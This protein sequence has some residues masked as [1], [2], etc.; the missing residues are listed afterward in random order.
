[1]IR[2][3]FRDGAS[4]NFG[5]Y[6]CAGAAKLHIIKNLAFAQ[7]KSTIHIA[8]PHAEIQ[9]SPGVVQ[10]HA[11]NF[12]DPRVLPIDSVAGD[13][14]IILHKRQKRRHF[15]HIELAV[16]VGIKNQFLCGC[17]DARLHRPAIAAIFRMMHRFDMRIC[18]G[19]LVGNFARCGLLL[20]SLTIITS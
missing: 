1:M 7:F 5:A 14:V 18:R 20:P 6:Q 9:N 17:P 10:H 19:K 2:Y 8:D 16:A 15:A 12:A 11:L 4:Q 13:H 3:P